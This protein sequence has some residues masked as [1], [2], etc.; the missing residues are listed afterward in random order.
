MIIIVTQLNLKNIWGFGPYDW[1]E[2][3]ILV[4][5]GLNFQR[6]RTGDGG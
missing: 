6:L 4:V 1:Y 2:S 3:K 5:V